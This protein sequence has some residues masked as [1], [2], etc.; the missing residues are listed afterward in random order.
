MLSLETMAA[1]LS[2]F[3][4]KSNLISC[5]MPLVLDSF[6]LVCCGLT[7]SQS[8]H[9]TGRGSLLQDCSLPPVYGFFLQ[10]GRSLAPM[11]IRVQHIC[12]CHETA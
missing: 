4:S 8:C 11:R 5:W 3:L 7:C 10:P 9:L 2:V 1:A 6:R 12:T